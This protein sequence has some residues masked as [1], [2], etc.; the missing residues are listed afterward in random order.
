MYISLKSFYGKLG[1]GIKYK[2]SDEGRDWYYINKIYVPKFLCFD[3]VE[4]VENVYVEDFFDEY[5]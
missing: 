3:Y 5:F 1:P 4:P 2:V